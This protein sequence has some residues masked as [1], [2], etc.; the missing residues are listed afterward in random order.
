VACLFQS[1]ELGATVYED[2]EG[3]AGQRNFR[4]QAQCRE[5]RN[6]ADALLKRECALGAFTLL[7]A[8]NA[9]LI[10]R[11]SVKGARTAICILSSPHL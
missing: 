11:Y 3:T 5:N 4:H 6:Q 10:A 9:A 7:L 2:R 1:R 8:F